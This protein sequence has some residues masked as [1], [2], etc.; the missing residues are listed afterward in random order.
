MYALLRVFIDICLLRTGPQSLPSSGFLFGLCLAAYALAGL[1]LALH[2]A[3]LLR[4]IGQ[5][6]VDAVIL[7]VLLYLLLRRRG[8]E[9]RFLQTAI[10]TVGTGALLGLLAL[11]VSYSVAGA[12][13]AASG[14]AGLSSLLLLALMLW[15]MIVLGHIVREA[16]SSTL[17]TGVLLAFGYVLI[18]LISI[19]I[20]F[21]G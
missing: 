15:S 20:L 1:L 16:I 21:P 2:D 12:A 3:S 13:E 19:G 18:S 17:G 11:P 8:L 6:L 7:L 4:A 14:E 9:P 5:I 10:A